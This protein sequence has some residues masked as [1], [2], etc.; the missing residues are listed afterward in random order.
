MNEYIIE[1][2]FNTT[3]YLEPSALNQ[4][5]NDIIYIHLKE[6][7][8]NKCNN[9]GYILKDSI[10]IINKSIGKFITVD[11]DKKIEFNIQYKATVISPNKGTIINCYIKNITKAG[12]I[13]YIKLSEIIKDYKDYDNFE[14]SPIIIMIP[15]NRI[16][17]N[18]I[19]IDELIKV[20]V[21]GIRIKFNAK[22]IQIVASPI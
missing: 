12:V 9:I 20:K 1:Q 7:I 3:I 4:N 8:E 15:N 17:D 10:K 16:S 14:N 18:E 6:K 2:L 11:N 5:I 21:T 22:N 13:A 19:K